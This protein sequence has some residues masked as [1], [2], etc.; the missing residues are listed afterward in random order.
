MLGGSS[1]SESWRN[2]GVVCG[3]VV[4]VVERGLRTKTGSGVVYSG[5]LMETTSPRADVLSIGR[6]GIRANCV[7]KEASRRCC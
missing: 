1:E 3:G 6:G 2:E 4:L 5:G 7:V